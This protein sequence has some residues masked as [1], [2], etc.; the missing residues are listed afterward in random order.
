MVTISEYKKRMNA[1]G[2]EFFVLILSGDIDL[3]Q[4]TLTGN[5]YATSKR[6][7][8]TTTFDEKTCKSLIGRQ[9]PGTIRRVECEPWQSVNESTGEVIT[10]HHRYAY[11]PQGET[12]E[13]NVF[14]GEVMGKTG[15]LFD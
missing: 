9:L 6:T 15:D 11:A 1:K 12:M 14:Q 7:S 5:F 3:V 8:I 4:S 2:E 13:E 10:H